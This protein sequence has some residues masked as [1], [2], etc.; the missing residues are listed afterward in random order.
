MVKLYAVFTGD[1]I[2]S[3]KRPEA[4]LENSISS[5]AETAR[6]LSTLTG[7]DTRF[8]RFRGD[9]WQFLLADPGQYLLAFTLLLARLRSTPETLQTRMAINIGPVD[10]IGTT[11]LS[12]ARGS[13]FT[14][15]GHALDNL[16]RDQDFVL[17]SAPTDPVELL[18]AADRQTS[19][20]G[21]IDWYDIPILGLVSFI[22]KRWT[23]AQAEAVALA[24]EHSGETQ[25]DIARRLG[26]TRQALNTRLVGAGFGPIRGAITFTKMF[27]GSNEPQL[28]TAAR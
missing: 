27:D 17:S 13:A 6:R 18:G 12:D 25:A 4:Q 22:A 26:I 7:T 28:A 1:I 15:S 5:L 10:Y 2:G 8:T 11:D 21:S 3:R 19:L 23:K 16:G 24:L 9:G 14:Q 20:L